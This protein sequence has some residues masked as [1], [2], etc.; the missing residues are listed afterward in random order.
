[1]V[2]EICRRTVVEAVAVTDKPLPTLFVSVTLLASV[3][4]KIFCTFFWMLEV[5][6]EVTLRTLVYARPLI[7]VAVMVDVTLT[8][9]RTD[10]RMVEVEVAVTFRDFR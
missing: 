4:D 5:V 8:V 9:L 2:F 6:V 3:D 7:K 1:M 10:L